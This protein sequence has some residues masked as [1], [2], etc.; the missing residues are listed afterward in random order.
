MAT[1]APLGLSGVE[2]E[3][4]Q[5]NL[6]ELLTALGVILKPKKVDNSLQ[7]IYKNRKSPKPQ[8]NTDLDIESLLKSLGESK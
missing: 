1:K 6:A 7:E 8:A 5:K 3:D 2:T 4:Y